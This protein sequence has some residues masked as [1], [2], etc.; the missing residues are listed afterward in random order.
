MVVCRQL[1]LVRRHAVKVTHTAVSMALPAMCLAHTR[2]ICQGSLMKT[3][4]MHRKV[5]L[6]FMQR[7]D[8][9]AVYHVE[10]PHQHN[11]H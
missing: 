9:L 8:L 11:I 5:A 10:F 7:S 3:E 1:Q 6:S 2:A 4:Q